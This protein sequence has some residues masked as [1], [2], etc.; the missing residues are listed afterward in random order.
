MILISKSTNNWNQVC[1]GG[2]IAAS[3]VIADKDP[4]LA[5]KTISRSLDGMPNALKQ[6]GPDGLYPEGATYWGYC[7]SFSVVTS[8]ILLLMYRLSM[9]VLF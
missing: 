5:A 3:I 1:N 7:T 8:S 9:G 4:Q 6:Y 2:M